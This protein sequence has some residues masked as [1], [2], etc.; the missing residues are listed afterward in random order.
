MAASPEA[1]ARDWKAGRFRPAYLFAGEDAAAKAAALKALKKALKVDELN[2]SEFS[3][4][5]E[6]QAAEIVS[7]CRTAPMFSER[8]LVVVRSLR[9]KAEARRALA[10][11][12][13]EP[14]PT[15]TLV[16]FATDGAAQKKG[17]KDILADAVARHGLT[18]TFGPL[19][20]EEA[21][22]RLKEEARQAGFE[23]PEEA[24]AAILDEA[25]TS[26]G[27]LKGEVEKIRL[28]LKG[29]KSCGPEDVLACL[30]FRR[31]AGPFELSNAIERRDLK[32]SIGALQRM[33]EE[34][35]SGYE[36]LPQISRAVNS[37][38]KAKRYLK[39]GVSSFEM[40]GKVRVFGPRQQP[41]L[42]ALEALSETRLLNDLKACLRTEADLKSKTWLDP[43]V[44]LGQLVGRLCR[45]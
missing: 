8:R 20:T 5:A 11:Y 35:S 45:K 15:T 34:G 25:G 40:W 6:D 2:V 31:D 42:K 36:I 12:L 19:G 16:L 39:A 28:F 7:V 3:G 41:F 44:E 18:L 37:Q 23:L 21:A 29:R 30:G 32:A 1:A 26:W 10:A 33:L 4:D 27:I 38:V 24:V 43:G 13:A 14:V 22:A 17:E 9:F